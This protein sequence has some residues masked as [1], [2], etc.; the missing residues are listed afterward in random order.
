MT[1][2]TT[3]IQA[4]F[5]S[6]RLTCVPISTILITDSLRLPLCPILRILRHPLL[7]LWP[8][9]RTSRYLSFV[10]FSGFSRPSLIFYLCPVSRIFWPLSTLSSLLSMPVCLKNRFALYSRLFSSSI[11]LGFKNLMFLAFP[12]RLSKDLTFSL[13]RLLFT[14]LAL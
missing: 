1:Y 3:T 7:L 13:S 12:F 11:P 14:D 6:A 9:L 4:N 10:Q 2:P 8:P 5:Y